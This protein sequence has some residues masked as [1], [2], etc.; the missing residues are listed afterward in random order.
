MGTFDTAEEAAR[1]YDAAARSIRGK[2]AKCNFP[3][4][5]NGE[6]PP[7]PISIEQRKRMA[8]AGANATEG[9]SKMIVGASPMGM[10]GSSMLVRELFLVCVSVLSF[11]KLNSFFFGFFDAEN[12]F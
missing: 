5:E 6:E 1:A 12:I 8:A 10:P 4:P 9:S 7:V 3:L 2:A 11:L